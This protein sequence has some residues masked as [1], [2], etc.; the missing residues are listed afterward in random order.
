MALLPQSLSGR[1]EFFESHLALWSTNATAIGS[2]AAR[3]AAIAAQTEAARAAMTAQAEAQ[4][5]AKSKTAALRQAVDALVDAGSV[6]FKEIRTKAAT[7]GDTVYQLANI[8]G[9]ATPGPIGELGKPT[10]IAATL[11]ERGE[12]LV[13]WKCTNPVG[14]T[15]TVYQ[16]WR[17][18]DGGELTYVG[19]T[20]AKEF[21]DTT[22]PQGTT[23]LVYQIQAVRSTSTGPWSLF[24]VNFGAASGTLATTMKPVRIAA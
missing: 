7:D 24:N 3:I 1:I 5:T 23:K 22:I 19:G 8:P 20:G 17:Q 2:S 21:T 11:S 15:G 18:A 14:A 13:T 16:V 10:D 6:L 4:E 12:L 9:P